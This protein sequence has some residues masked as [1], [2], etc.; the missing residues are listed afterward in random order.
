MSMGPWIWAGPSSSARSHRSTE[1]NQLSEWPATPL[2]I[3]GI[4]A[5]FF[6]VFQSAQRFR[7]VA[8]MR[9]RASAFFSQLFRSI[10]RAYQ[11]MEPLTNSAQMSKL[12]GGKSCP[13]AIRTGYELGL[14]KQSWLSQNL[15]RNLIAHYRCV[16]IPHN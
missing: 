2:P 3:R 1:N 12:V 14:A 15:P 6:V 8:A 11:D 4:H 10:G 13:C 5:A 9:V 16:D 7:C